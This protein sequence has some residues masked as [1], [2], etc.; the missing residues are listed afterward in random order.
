[1]GMFAYIQEHRKIKA[2]Y[3]AM[4]PMELYVEKIKYSDRHSHDF[5]ASLDVEACN[6]NGLSV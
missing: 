6:A 1:M 4:D 5:T 3:E 2:K